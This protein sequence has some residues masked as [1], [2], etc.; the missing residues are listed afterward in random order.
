V[1]SAQIRDATCG[2]AVRIVNEDEFKQT[3]SSVVAK[4]ADRTNCQ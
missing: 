1:I 4:T 3:R 2:A